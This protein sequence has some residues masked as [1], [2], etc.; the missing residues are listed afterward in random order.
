MKNCSN[1]ICASIIV[2]FVV[3]IFVYIDRSNLFNK[4]S[5]FYGSAQNQAQVLQSLSSLDYLNSGDFAIPGQEL[6]NAPSVIVSP[7]QPTLESP[8]NIFFQGIKDFLGGL[9]GPGPT[10]EQGF[11][12]EIGLPPNYEGGLSPSEPDAC[13]IYDRQKMY[14][15]LGETYD[16]N[17]TAG[18]FRNSNI[19]ATIDGEH[20]EEVASKTV[21]G[22]KWEPMVLVVNNVAYVFGGKYKSSGGAH[23]L[24]SYM[25]TDMVN[26]SYLGELPPMS[27]E[28]D[29]S[30]VYFKGKFWLIS[31]EESVG[32]W[33][34]TNG[35]NWKQEV[36][37]NIWDGRTYGTENG[38]DTVSHKKGGYVSNSMGAYVLNN[39][40]W[41]VVGNHQ[42]E[43]GSNKKVYSST[44]GVNW[45][46]EGVFKI[47][48][49]TDQVLDIAWNTNPSPIM[50]RGEAWVISSNRRTGEP[51][52][53][54]TANGRDWKLVSNYR[55][56]FTS[57]R[58]Y[59]T[60]VSFNGKLWT[61]GGFAG[62]P[63]S[64]TSYDVWSSINGS[65]WE[66]VK[67]IGTKF[68]APADRYLAGGLVLTYK[69]SKGGPDLRISTNSTAKFSYPGNNVKSESLGSWTIKADSL[70]GAVFDGEVV[71]SGIKIQGYEFRK[72]SS[73]L[74]YL[75][76][77][78]VYQYDQTTNY[79]KLVG[80]V[81]RLNQPYYSYPEKK[82]NSKT[83]KLSSPI[84]LKQGES[85]QITITADFS[86][87]ESFNKF[88][89]YLV[90]DF[91]FINEESKACSINSAYGESRLAGVPGYTIILDR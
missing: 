71:I 33:S 8:S 40:I 46:D 11:E 35:S 75:R 79:K 26:W 89:T 72:G 21:M 64:L 7:E 34:S 57:P 50:L 62:G 55:T 41:Y 80:E 70:S 69:Y 65:V 77:F 2:I 32:I 3:S 66:N 60:M 85:T 53:I 43:P 4:E 58:Y 84:I 67:Q 24:S 20:W 74:G 78:K 51:M 83:I 31:S 54:K 38:S 86:L 27:R 90:P 6:Q 59:S 39:K 15:L 18:L 52:V 48:G 10:N 45:I 16:A 73:S 12:Q 81:S 61:I 76:N 30:M 36:T 88:I 5:E 56:N 49:K 28:F 44:D 25:S 82:P 23:D 42:N 13:G 29:K 19:W 22:E 87:N 63:Q 14:V 37:K 91:E 47:D 1:K 68:T 17:G 9:V